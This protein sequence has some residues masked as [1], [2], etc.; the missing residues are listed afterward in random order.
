[1]SKRTAII[2]L[3]FVVALAG[4][5]TGCTTARRPMNTTDGY[6]RTGMNTTDGYNRTGMN[7]S[8]GN[9]TGNYQGT[10]PYGSTG[11][12]SKTGDNLGIRDWSNNYGTDVGYGTTGTN[13]AKNT[14]TYNTR[15][16]NL[17]TNVN[18]TTTTSNNI[19]S[20]CKRV[21]GVTNAQAVVTGN[22]AYVGIDTN[23]TTHVANERDIKNRVAEAVRAADKN[24][25]T[26]YVSTDIS[27][28]DRIRSVEAGLRS[29]RPIDA[30]TT[31]LNQMV[32]KI[33]PTRW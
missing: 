23:K 22:T 32:Q 26:V 15:T 3:V 5:F 27:F 21:P 11:N 4:I 19:A 17:G 2:V 31:E 29:G 1:M 18:N 16:N 9:T 24:I 20:A 8:Y 33:T 13:V 6:N 12:Y 28:M 30:F 14:G 25:N 10:T 7:T